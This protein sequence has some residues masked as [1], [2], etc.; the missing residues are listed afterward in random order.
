[1][2][3]LN[4]DN[5]AF[6]NICHMFISANHQIQWVVIPGLPVFPPSGH[7]A[8]LGFSVLFKCPCAL[9]WSVK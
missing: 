3:F 9:F 8:Q 2:Y 7:W 1:M 5:T 4:I 6:N